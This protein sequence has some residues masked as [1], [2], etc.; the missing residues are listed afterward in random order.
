MQPPN[1]STHTDCLT[2]RDFLLSERAWT[3]KARL[4]AVS[5]FSGAGLSDIGYELAGFQFVVQAEKDPRRAS[6]CSANF[7]EAASIVGQIGKT[8]R[9]VASVYRAK[10]PEDRLA[11]L[12]VTPPCQGLSSSNPSRGK[13]S[14]HTTSDGRNLLLLDALDLIKE[15]EPKLVVVENV[16]QVLHRMVKADGDEEPGKLV[17]I[18]QSALCST[19]RVFSTVVQMANYGIP[20]DRRR[21][22]LVAVHNG[23]PGLQLLA[24]ESSLPIPRPSHSQSSQGSSKSWVTLEKWL[25]AMRY[26]TLDAQSLGTARDPSDQLHFVPHYGD[27]R[28]LM[29]A[30][31]P[32]RSGQNAYQN[33]LCHKCGHND[34]PKNAANCP[35][36]SSLMRNKPY[37]RDV[38]GHYR[39]IKGFDSSYRRMH[40]DRPAPTVTTASSHLGSDYKIH[41]WENRVLSIRECADLQ[42]VPRFYHWEWVFD[43]HQTYLAREVIGEALPPMFTYLHGQILRALVAGN[44]D[45]GQLMYNPQSSS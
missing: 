8:W 32:P 25:T 12:S 33:S 4:P 23:E 19:Y 20:Q 37:M 27:D 7:P 18:F 9:E 11:L 10:K 21:A 6:L 30:D 31:I 34:V 3:G 5:L 1:C 40:P 35:K 24:R 45:P 41:P 26:P 28:Y 13:V 36:C 17:D 15:L 29:V 38:A 44:I 39:L 43:H 42:T 22:V 16:P 2:A 14:D